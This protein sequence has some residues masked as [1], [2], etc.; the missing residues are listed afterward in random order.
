MVLC[1]IYLDHSATTPPRPEAIARMQQILT[2]EWGNPSSTHEWG[3]RGAM[4]LEYA[5]SQLADLLNAPAESLIFTSGGTEANNLAILGVAHQYQQ[6]QHII[7]SAVEH[8]A[9]SEPVSWL[10]QWG[11]QVTR[12]PVDRWGRVD[13]LSL[14]TAL[15]PETVLVS[16]I[17]GQSEV[18]TIQPIQA[19]GEIIQ[20]WRRQ[21]QSSIL[22]HTDAVQVVGRLRIDVRYLPV[23]LLSLSSHKLYGPQGAGALYIRPGVHLV[24]L[25]AGGGQELKLRSGTQALPTIAGFGVAAE[26][27]NQDLETEAERLQQLRDRLFSHLMDHP[28]LMPTGD[29]LH[30]LPHHVS[31]CLGS[32]SN[33]AILGKMDPQVTGKTIVR[34][35]NLAGIGISSGSACSSGKTLPSPILSAMGLRSPYC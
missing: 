33:G 22:F 12:L 24:P 9:I 15:K 18:G 4:V 16:V 17:Y 6:P 19:L 26:L 34:Q 29:R 35:M 20:N 30:R 28:W 5:R 8:P 21:Y 32:L 31:F 1:K 2:E 10:E 13:P 3:Q 23:D 11:W 7:I 14:Q 27:A 25:L